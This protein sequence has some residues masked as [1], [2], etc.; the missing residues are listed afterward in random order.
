MR[1]LDIGPLPERPRQPQKKQLRYTSTNWAQTTIPALE[2]GL[3]PLTL[4]MDPERIMDHARAK[5]AKE[6]NWQEISPDRGEDMH[7]ERNTRIFRWKD[8]I[9]VWFRA[10][11]KGTELWVDSCSRIGRGD[12]GQNARNIRELFRLLS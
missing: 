11:D 5:L 3:E 8:D 12:L 10:A 6:S 4:P 7:L 9:R 2:D 1:I